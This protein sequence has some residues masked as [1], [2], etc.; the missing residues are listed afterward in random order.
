[1]PFLYTVF[2]GMCMGAADI[3]P[4]I[5]G[6]TVAFIM[7]FYNQLIDG[8]KNFSLSNFSQN[9]FLLAL[10]LG[11]SIS[12]IS[13][14]RFFD[15][16][17]GHETYR[18]Y[19]YASF[20]GLILASVVFCAKQIE[21]WSLGTLIAFGLGITI[22]V[23]LTGTALK[24]NA[25][26]PLYDLYIPIKATQKQLTNYDVSRQSLVAVPQSTIA[27]MLA[28]GLLEP[29]TKAFSHE[30]QTE[31]SIASLM[32]FT[33]TP[34]HFDV[35]IIFCGAMAISAMLLPGI[36]GSY[37]LTIFGVYPLVITALADVVEAA[38]SLT[39]DMEGIT[40]L[41]NLLLG[42]IIG[43]LVFS[44]VASWL[45]AQYRNFSIALL[46]GFMIGALESVWPFWSYEYVLNP[47]KLERGAQL[48]VVDPILPEM[49]WTL[50]LS[51]LAMMAGFALVLL[52]EYL[53]NRKKAAPADVVQGP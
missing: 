6:G 5:S 23:L 4:G 8:I 7:G 30:K 32:A 19:L 48:Q 37:L 29:E 41:S 49:G 46:T 52:V 1:M 13:L 40:L 12:L 21:K 10:I 28:K 3:V 27:A 16:L 24:V 43:G 45:L 50:A 44:R 11:I 18:I 34:N 42:I 38:K 26:E 9:K 20:L 25:H 51:V 2:C 33:L 31:G 14:V 47:L 15:F 35:W 39:I 22:A 36:S 17:L 53:A